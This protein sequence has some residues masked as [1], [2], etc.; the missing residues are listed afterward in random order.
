[1][2]PIAR[3]AA[4]GFTAAADAYERARPGYPAAAVA[5]LAERLAIGPGRTVLDLAAGT[6]KLTR[7]LVPLGARVVAVEPVAAMRSKLQ[8]AAPEAEALEGTAEAIP[9]GDGSVDTV[10]VAQ[11]FHWFDARAAL[12]EIHRVL[13]PGGG[14]GLVWNLRDDADELTR[15]TEELLAPHKVEVSGLWAFDVEGDLTR[16]GRFGPVEAAT[17]PHEQRLDLDTFVDRFASTSYVADL[18][19]GPREE[20]LAELRRLGREAGEPIVV[21]YVT[22]AFAAR[23]A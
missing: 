22:E 15:R 1:M 12:R 16:S 20:L 3:V 19:A 11:A 18:P 9:L 5:W 21:R 17:W 23:R 6:G 2:T 13:A 7:S 4:A 14:I 8:Q 10:L